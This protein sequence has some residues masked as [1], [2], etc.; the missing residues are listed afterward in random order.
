MMAI[1]LVSVCLV[2]LVQGLPRDGALTHLISSWFGFISLHGCAACVVR[3]STA[4]PAP[5]N[6]GSVPNEMQLV[7][8]AGIG[9]SYC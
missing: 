7:E 5:S 6:P 2:V 3:E 1:R 4:G 8:L 9:T